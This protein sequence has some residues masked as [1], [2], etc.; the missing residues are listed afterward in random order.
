MIRIDNALYNKELIKKIEC[1]DYCS[2][3]V[4]SEETYDI[5][6]LYKDETREILEYENKEL[7]D[8]I[9]NSITYLGL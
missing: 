6:I 7:R 3:I 8:N 5:H 9:F 4:E 1:D 2:R